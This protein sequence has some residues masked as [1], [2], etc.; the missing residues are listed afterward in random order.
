M[1]FIG[2]RS[3][4][5]RGSNEQLYNDLNDNFL[6]ACDMVAKFDLVM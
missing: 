1:K 5:F 2:K 4:A 6:A 3:L